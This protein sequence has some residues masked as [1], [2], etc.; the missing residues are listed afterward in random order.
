MSSEVKLLVHISIIVLQFYIGAIA[1][2]YPDKLH[3]GHYL[4]VLLVSIPMIIKY[5][6]KNSE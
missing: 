3:A 2:L 6:K 4:V 5:I 1:F